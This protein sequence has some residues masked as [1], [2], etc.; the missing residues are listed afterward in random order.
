MM[1]P[2]RDVV[3]SCVLVVGRGREIKNQGQQRKF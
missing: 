3:F 1:S 2:F